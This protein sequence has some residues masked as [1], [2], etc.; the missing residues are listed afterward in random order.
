MQVGFDSAFRVDPPGRFFCEL[1]FPE[2]P[3][4]PPRDPYFLYLF[5]A[6]TGYPVASADGLLSVNGLAIAGH[7]GSVDGQA[8]FRASRGPR[9]STDNPP[10][11]NSLPCILKT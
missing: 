10:H 1:L 7:H 8:A 6:T 5:A 4:P 3:H 9:P 2:L 11:E